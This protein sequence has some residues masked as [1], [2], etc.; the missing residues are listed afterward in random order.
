MVEMLVEHTDAELIRRCQ[1]D[2]PRAVNELYRRYR[3]KVYRIA[4][5]IV[6]D[7]D[8]ALDVMQDVFLH[9]LKGIGAFRFQ[10]SFS[11]WITRVTVNVSID[12]IRKR[13]RMKSVVFQA[14]DEEGVESV[15]VRSDQAKLVRA[16]FDQ[17]DPE[18]RSCIILREIEGA[19]YQEIAETMRCSIG[20]VRSRIHRARRHLRRILKDVMAE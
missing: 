19:S 17:L 9:V 18:Q 20:T 11:T 10:S 2:D 7:H 8:D 3:E 16:A 1:E 15:V 5:R 6:L 4:C 13:K 14:A 12:W